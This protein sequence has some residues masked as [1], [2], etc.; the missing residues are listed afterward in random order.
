MTLKQHLPYLI[1]CLFLVS[2]TKI[3]A[4][5]S[6]TV[7]WKTLDG[8]SIPIPPAHHPRLY[9]QK[10][11]IPDLKQRFHNPKLK[12]ILDELTK[13][14]QET[15]L[16]DGKVKTWREYTKQ[17]GVTVESELNAAK[18][19][20]TKDPKIGRKAITDI[21]TKMKASDWPQ[22]Q[23]I[24]RAAGRLMVSGAV[25]YDWCYDLITENEKQEFV[26]EFLRLANMLECGYPPVKQT[27]VTGHSSEWMI[28]RDLLS[29]SIAI[30]DEFPEMYELT[31]KRIF[32]EH[33]P[34]RN[35]FYSGHAYHQ[36][37]A[38]NRVRY[39]ADLFATWI[40][41]R[42]GAGNVFNP[43]QGEMPYYWIYSRRPDGQFLGS[44]DVNYSRSGISSLA[45]P[46]LLAGGYYQNEHFNYEYEQ[47]PNIASIDLF[48][49]F[50]W[51][52]TSLGTKK[53]DD[54]A[55]TRYF[56]KPFGWMIARTGWGDNSVIAEMKINEYNFL[57]HQH[58][59]AGSFQIYY[60][61][62][63]AID[64]GM[65]QGSSG[66]YNSPHN[67][68]YFKRTIAHN[69]L[70]IYDPNETFE[71]MGYGGSDKS[72]TVANDGGQR[73]PGNGWNP[74][75]HL[76]DLLNK[77]YKTGEILANDFSPSTTAPDYSYLK[78]DIT[79]AYSNKVKEVKRS[80]TFLNL[81]N[82]KTPAA[83]IVFDK[84][85]SSDKSFKKFWLL[86]SIEEPKI[87]HNTFEVTRTLNDDS[88]KLITSTLLPSAEDLEIKSVGGEGKEFWVFGKNYPNEPTR[89]PD[90]ANERGA[91]RVELSP[92]TEKET[93]YFLNVIQITDNQNKK[94][95]LVSKLEGEKTIGVQIDDRVVIYSHASQILETDFSFSFDGK[96]TFKILVT[97]LKSGNWEIKKGGKTLESKK[98]E[99]TSSTVYF[100]G[101]KG[102]YTFVK[103]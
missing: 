93:D 82:D 16:D 61:G 55:L 99:E 84:I 50:L 90:V 39:S 29:A 72:P 9:L 70:L 85:V 75:Q 92:K 89:R 19:L 4:Q 22:V 95:L 67:K 12:P 49:E 25:V 42:M 64:S 15:V 38:Y 80:F 24:A 76:E 3:N 44:G 77:D 43:E 94:P 71:S 100:E 51:K 27:S 96:G 14:S 63:L 8:I 68:N 11:H 41:D 47:R 91:W 20:T 53:P 33:I 48:F 57:N 102:T 23:D 88:G 1:A 21:L 54:L 101:K 69:S 31:A 103:Q 98:V 40:F 87:N 37:N 2:L 30:Y 60:K 18:Y 58:H 66:G 32:K 46:G 7:E 45:L 83:L 17:Q 79:E 56:G 26:V 86:H 59:D 35:W 78:G 81:H 13:M 6:S 73:L 5:S 62:P 10:E 36:G 28:M 52:D 65:Y 97:D 34:V 74:P